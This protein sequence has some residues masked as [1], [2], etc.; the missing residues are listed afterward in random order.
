MSAFGTKRT[1]Q[2]RSANVRFW[3]FPV[4][5]L[6][7]QEFSADLP[8]DLRLALQRGRKG[9]WMRNRAGAL[10]LPGTETRMGEARERHSVDSRQTPERDR[11]QGTNLT[12]YNALS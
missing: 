3:G 7:T 6:K 9:P 5:P 11:F 4:T 12:R 10:P 2:S 8:P 1:W